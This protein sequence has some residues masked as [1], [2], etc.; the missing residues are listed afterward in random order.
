MGDGDVKWGG[1]V[2]SVPCWTDGVVACFASACAGI[3]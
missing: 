3:V 2:Q 1:V